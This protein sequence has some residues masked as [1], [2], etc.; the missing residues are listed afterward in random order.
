MEDI[1]YAFGIGISFS[2]GIITGATLCV[3]TTRKGLEKREE[4]WNTRQDGIE[5]RL[6]QTLLQTT[7][8]ADAA[9]LFL[10]TK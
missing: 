9:E 4:R 10:K 7:R 6:A 5:G 8:L 3:L 2:I 1:I